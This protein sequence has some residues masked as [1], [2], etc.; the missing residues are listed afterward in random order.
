M[1]SCA[2]GGGC[3]VGRTK[4]S[5]ELGGLGNTEA[6]T[7]L[8]CVATRRENVG[9]KPGALDRSAGSAC[10][11]LKCLTEEF[12]LHPESSGEPRRGFNQERN[13][14]TCAFQKDPPGCPWEVRLEGEDWDLEASQEAGVNLQQ[15]YRELA[16]GNAGEAGGSGADGRLWTILWQISGTWCCLG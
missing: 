10:K 1:W 11:G 4:K 13:A 6:H 9:Q 7:W 16:E 3:F 8:V 5:P 12:V 15:R 14:I 2:L